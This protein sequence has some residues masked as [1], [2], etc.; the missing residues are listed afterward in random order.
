MKSWKEIINNKQYIV[1]EDESKV[2]FST[3]LW[4]KI[5]KSGNNFVNF[6]S[7]EYTGLSKIKDDSAFN[8]KA[9]AR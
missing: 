8:F 3:R 9:I 2:E 1:S 7:D 5:V 6:S 4:N